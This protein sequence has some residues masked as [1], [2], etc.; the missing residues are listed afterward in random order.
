MNEFDF[1][2][3]ATSHNRFQSGQHIWL[4]NAEGDRIAFLYI[5]KNIGARLIG[6]AYD[7]SGIKNETWIGQGSR[8]FSHMQIR[9]VGAATSL[10][11]GPEPRYFLAA[12]QDHCD[13]DNHEHDSDA[14]P[15]LLICL[16]DDP[17][18]ARPHCKQSPSCMMQAI[19]RARLQRAI[20]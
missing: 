1:L 11:L 18:Q 20:R 16:L 8:Q 2:D 9:H 13:N 15:I 5:A 4:A 6:E 3:A 10:H 7:A 17:E 14:A 19:E 12:W